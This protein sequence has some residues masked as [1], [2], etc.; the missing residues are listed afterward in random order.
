MTGSPKGVHPAGRGATDALTPVSPRAVTAAGPGA[1]LACRLRS[2]WGALGRKPPSQ[3][4]WGSIGPVGS[5][6]WVWVGGWAEAR[7][8]RGL[9]CHPVAVRPR[10][11]VRWLAPRLQ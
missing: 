11:L 6:W 5:L 1:M 10:G 7:P 8:G 3:E 9:Q 2:G 4:C